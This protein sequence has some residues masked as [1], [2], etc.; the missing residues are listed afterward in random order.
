MSMKPKAL[1]YREFVSVVTNGGYLPV[2]KWCNGFTAFNNGDVIVRINNIPLKPPPVA[3]VSGESVAIGG[4][5]GEVYS[6]QSL[7][8]IFDSGGTNPSVV[9]IQKVY[10]ENYFED[11]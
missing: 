6:A 3:T 2:H 11:V 9:I 1:R 7:K 8:I 5:F 10:N 4:N